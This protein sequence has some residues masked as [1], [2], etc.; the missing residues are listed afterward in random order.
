MLS[1]Y[2]HISNMHSGRALQQGA[3]ARRDLSRRK[4]AVPPDLVPV[5]FECHYDGGDPCAIGV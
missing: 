5:C 3:G 2:L 4:S 1:D